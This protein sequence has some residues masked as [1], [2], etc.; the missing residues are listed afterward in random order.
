M[1]DKFYAIEDEVLIDKLKSDFNIGLSDKEVLKRQEKYGLNKLPAKKQDSLLKIFAK[2]I[3]D[4]IVIMLIVTIIFSIIIH[5]YVDAL[6]INFIV[7]ADLILGAYQEWRAEKNALSLQNLI[8][9]NVKCIRNS[10]EVIVDS[11]ELVIGD[12]VLLESGDKISADMRVLENSNLQVSEAILTGES[13]NVYKNHEVL[14]KNTPLP[15]RRNMVYAGCDVITGRARCIVCAT[16]TDTE[17]GKIAKKVNT[18][19]DEKSPLTIRMEKLS[20]QI[21]V[22][23][24]VVG[25]MVA[26]ALYTNGVSGTEIFL[27][28]IALS[29]SAMPE[30]LPLALTMALSKRI[31]FVKN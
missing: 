12:I 15:E 1:D 30:G 21:T 24:I 27:S 3:L 16:A 23:I 2:G 26:I 22:L 9:Y 11:S 20:K 8:K 28:V 10:E 13:T 29:V 25:I 18:I 4:P 6:V 17:V 14:D 19:K 7:L 5:E 31:L